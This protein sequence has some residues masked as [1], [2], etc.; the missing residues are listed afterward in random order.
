M[1]NEN[2]CINS[3]KAISILNSFVKIFHILS[4]LKKLEFE[5]ILHFFGSKM[6]A[7][8]TYT[9]IFILKLMQWLVKY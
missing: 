9:N 5:N 3:S 4:D 2:E 1:K 7:Y 6:L 8:E